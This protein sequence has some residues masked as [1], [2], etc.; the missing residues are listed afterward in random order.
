[1]LYPSMMEVEIGRNQRIRGHGERPRSFKAASLKLSLLAVMAVSCLSCVGTRP[2]DAAGRNSTQE[3][4]LAGGCFWGMEGVFETLKGVDKVVSGYAGGSRFTARYPIVSTGLTGHAES[5]QITYDP[6]R[7]SYA[8]LLRIY[9]LVAHDPTELNR[10]GYDEGTQYRSE[11]F[12]TSL[13][14]KNIAESLIRT[15]TASKTFAT[16]IVTKIAPLRGFYAAEAYHQHYMA[17]HPDDP[18]IA[19]NDAPKIEHLKATFP[20]LIAPASGGLASKARAETA[21]SGTK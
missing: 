13:A 18:Y 14:Q 8:T 4:V 3:A 19:Q 1:M 2:A 17:T 5:V 7:I 12:Y 21:T 9:F 20:T 10:Q 11:I 6:R 16:P 15:L